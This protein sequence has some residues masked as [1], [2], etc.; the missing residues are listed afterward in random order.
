MFFAPR[1][2]LLEPESQCSKPTMNTRKPAK[3]ALEDGAIYD[4]YSFGA[5]GEVDG[6]V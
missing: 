5:D 3:L 6:E 1:F 4:G 2:T